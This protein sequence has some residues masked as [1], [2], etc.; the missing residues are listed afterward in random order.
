VALDPEFD[1]LEASLAKHELGHITVFDV[2]E[3]SGKNTRKGVDA[4]FDEFCST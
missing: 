2:A 3:E 4:I 1:L